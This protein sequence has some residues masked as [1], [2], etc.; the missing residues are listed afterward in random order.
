MRGFGHVPEAA[1][2]P[3]VQGQCTWAWGGRGKDNRVLAHLLSY[4]SRVRLSET[5]WTDSSPLSMGFSRQEYWSGLPCPP[6]GDLP[7]LGGLSSPGST[8]LVCKP[9]RPVFPDTP[10]R[11]SLG[12]GEEQ[13]PW[14][15]S[16]GLHSQDQP[17]PPCVTSGRLT[18]RP[19]FLL[20]NS[21]DNNST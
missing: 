18:P 9:R 3:V 21:D 2:R 6:P 1:R 13:R 19:Q 10:P 4:F 7:D 15:E 5:L 17:G 16:L 11:D 12:L 14:S 20:Q 8:V